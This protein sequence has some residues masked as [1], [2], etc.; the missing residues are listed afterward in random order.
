MTSNRRE[1]TRIARRPPEA[2]T[3]IPTGVQ[4]QLPEE[5]VYSQLAVTWRVTVIH[6]EHTGRSWPIAE[7]NN[8]SPVKTRLESTLLEGFAARGVQLSGGERQRLERKDEGEVE[9]RKPQ[10]STPSRRPSERA[11]STVPQTC[12]SRSLPP[13]TNSAESLG[14]LEG[15]SG[16]S[17]SSTRTA[18]ANGGTATASTVLGKYVHCILLNRLP[19]SRRHSPKAGPVT[20]QKPRTK[21]PASWSLLHPDPARP[22]S[23]RQP[24]TRRPCPFRT[25]PVELIEA[26]L[27]AC[28]EGLETRKE[29][30]EMVHTL[31]S[32]ATWI[33]QILAGLPSVWA[34]IHPALPKQFTKRVISLSRSYP[35]SIQYVPMPAHS[36]GWQTFGVFIQLVGEARDRWDS[37]DGESEVS[38]TYNEQLGDSQPI[39]P[40]RLLDGKQGYLRRLELKNISYA[41]DPTSFTL[42]TSIDLMQGVCMSYQGVLDFL[43]SS[44]QL[45]EL[46]RADLN[47]TDGPPRELWQPLVLPQL[48]QLML[49]DGVARVRMIKLYHSIRADNCERLTLKVRGVA[50]MDRPELVVV[51]QILE[52]EAQRTLRFG[53]HEGSAPRSGKGVGAVHSFRLGFIGDALAHAMH[54]PGAIDQVLPLT[55]SQMELPG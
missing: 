38:T 33:R 31:N 13:K 46:H 1:K 50:E 19:G 6:D 35:L 49:A 42:F 44:C 20:S 10:E 17:S 12:S 5:E 2:I 41:F 32:V 52:T 27:E 28:F 47:F 18:R 55:P 24:D 29:H 37:L 51:Q 26:V 21:G 34:V 54:F 22:W 3:C 16:P 36:E 15:T 7:G 39:R 40:F 14:A 9:C 25:L 23:L 11:L 43:T 4:K 53:H 30:V 45:E 8:A 48:K